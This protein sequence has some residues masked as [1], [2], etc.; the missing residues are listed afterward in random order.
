MSKYY[1]IEFL[2]PNK[3]KG[4]LIC[5]EAESK[6]HAKVEGPKILASGTIYSPDMFIV[7]NVKK[8]PIKNLPLEKQPKSIIQKIKY[9]I[10][11]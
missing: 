11:F 3:N 5:L 7:L 9:L 10:K 1:D 4:T 8:T 6:N 2:N